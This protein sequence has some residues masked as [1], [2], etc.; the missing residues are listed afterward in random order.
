M[1]LAASAPLAVLFAAV[2]LL[3]PISGAALAHAQAQS[4]EEATRL[5]LSAA[6]GANPTPSNACSLAEA[7]RRAGMVDVAARR[8]DALLEAVRVAPPPEDD[9]V[10]PSPYQ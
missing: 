10:I 2:S 1:R 7:E 9:E 5:R 3:G 4:E 6:Y 8:L